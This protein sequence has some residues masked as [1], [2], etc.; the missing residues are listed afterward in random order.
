MV[1]AD[2][3]LSSCMIAEDCLRMNPFFSFTSDL[4]AQTM[5]GNLFPLGNFLP[6]FEK[7]RA[8]YHD[9]IHGHLHR[10]DRPLCSG[11]DSVV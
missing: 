6:S 9:R 1:H 2:N 3:Y 5:N 8:G 7:H 4:E 11:V 10:C